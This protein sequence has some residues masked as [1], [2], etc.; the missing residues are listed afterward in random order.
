MKGFSYYEAEVLNNHCWATSHNRERGGCVLLP[1]VELSLSGPG[2]L[3]AVQEAHAAKK[4]IVFA[5]DRN[6]SDQI[7]RIGYFLDSGVENPDITWFR[8]DEIEIT[9][10]PHDG[11]HMSDARLDVDF[12]HPKER[13]RH[14]VLNVPAGPDQTILLRVLYRVL[15]DGTSDFVI[16]AEVRGLIKGKAEWKPV[17]RYDCA[18]GFLHRDLMGLHG[19][20]SKEP[21]PVE[22]LR[23]AIPLA[24]QELRENLGDWLTQLGYDQPDASNL[25]HPS[26]ADELGPAEHVLLQL[27]ENP[28]SVEGV[29]SRSIMF[30]DVTGQTVVRE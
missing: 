6:A 12:Q 18:H 4:Q 21:I 3:R 25:G 5:V 15:K 1:G 17:A 28:E 9:S 23:D 11:P 27:L 2:F 22:N 30:A 16:Q 8:E 24:L 13:E 26:L 7:V 19:G 20:K 10:R 14:F 29:A